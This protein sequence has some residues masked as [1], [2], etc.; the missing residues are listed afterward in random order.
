MRVS[1]SPDYFTPL[2]PGHRFPMGKFPA[3]RQALLDERLIRPADI[4]EPDEAEWADLLRV[5]TPEYLSDLAHGSLSDRAIRRLGLPWSSALVRRSRLAVQGTLN[6][7]RFALA[8][9]LGANLAGGTHH[10]FP[11]RGEGFCVLNDI[12]VAVRVLLAEGAARRVLI[13]DVDTHQGNGTA[14]C[15]RDVPQAFTLSLHGARNYPFQKERS[16]RDVPLPDDIGDEQY[17]ATLAAAL[18]SAFDRARP[19]LVVCLAGVD[20]VVGDRFGRLNLTETG[21]ARRDHLIAT[22]VFEKGLPL[23]LTLSGG[24]AATPEETA[25]LHASAHRQAIAVFE[26]PRPAGASAE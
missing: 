16:S 15:L 14:A 2:P 20:V 26:S 5:H 13:V 9:G 8:D 11:D 24:Y 18:D 25:R 12:A 6:A 10:A 1:Y 19:D 17:L 22:S 4:V 3:L 7:A 23:A 21:L